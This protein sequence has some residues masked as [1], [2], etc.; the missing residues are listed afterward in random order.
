MFNRS[1]LVT[2]TICL[3]FLLPLPG[4]GQ[5]TGAL[6]SPPVA[7]V[8]TSVPLDASG[9]PLL[10][11]KDQADKE[12]ESVKRRPL[13]ETSS[14]E[15]EFQNYVHRNYGKWLPV[16]GLD[17]FSFDDQG[18]D[19]PVHSTPSE[20]YE[21][22]IGDEI[23]IKVT[24]PIEL[25][26]NLVV[27]NT[28]FISLPRVGG[29]MVAG[30]RRS[31]LQAVIGKAIARL[32]TGYKLHVYTGKLRTISV[33]VV[34]HAAR[35]GVYKVSA[36][37]S[38]LNVIYAAGGPAA[39]G[40]LRSI[41]LMRNGEQRAVFDFYEVV[42][43]GSTRGDV[44]LRNGDVIHFPVAGARVAL[45]GA[46]NLQA[47]FE[48]ASGGTTVANLIHAAGG[49]PSASRVDRVTVD[50]LDRNNPDA[51]KKVLTLNLSGAEAETPLQDGDVLTVQEV[52]SKFANMVSVRGAV[53]QP[54]RRAW[55]PGMR[56]SDLIPGRSALYSPETVRARNELA[57][58]QRTA[59]KATETKPLNVTG[60]RSVAET[61]ADARLE[62][63]VP[64]DN[65]NWNLATV[66]R[67]N[68][69]TGQTELLHFNLGRALAAPGSVDDLQLQAGDQVV[70][71]S[72]KSL[73]L[74]EELRTR[75][76][77]IDGEVQ[78]PGVYQLAAGETLPQLLARAGGVTS[79]AF[80][81]GL[82]FTR[83]SQV[84]LQREQLQKAAQ[85]MEDGIT[86]Q[87][88]EL[89]GAGQSAEQRTLN[90]ALIAETRLR[91][92][93]LKSQ[94]PD[95]RIAVD[96]PVEAK[97]ADLPDLVLEDGDTVWVPARPNHVAVF[98]A[99]N[100][101]LTV[102]WDSQR[103]LRSYL[104]AASPKKTADLSEVYVI[105]ANGRA[106]AVSSGMFSAGSSVARPGDTVFVP[107]EPVRLGLTS[108]WMNSLKDWS[109]IMFQLLVGASAAKGL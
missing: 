42:T 66:E 49:L 8:M 58:G 70:V 71:Y 24:G 57:M 103:S 96:I 97:M 4:M 56:V 98:G 22:G 11:L 36:T 77:R 87:I 102:M 79:R 10:Q 16:Y 75:Y 21:V 100:N 106:E 5:G 67:I 65:V 43:Q 25:D 35:P 55:R 80:L 107:E 39:T 72:D 30:V 93:V 47:I 27:D 95:G 60:V 23:R 99:V 76:V 92:S 51:P 84:R 41:R 7:P 74:P 12:N 20:L 26:A 29:V 45:I 33:L 2:A 68:A 88:G 19:A 40:S 69:L 109:Q 32:Y 94:Q 104:D 83:A 37:S 9:V 54:L 81:Y 34:G 52:G 15:L 44:A 59:R 46:S 38:L 105:R 89:L 14:Q 62:S 82:K 90:E 53:F 86:A 50:R 91:A 1:R 85:L 61:I 64:A 73:A 101:P 17:A 18:F 78:G 6:S 48:L 13:T 31:E 28:G 63:L 108:I 3:L